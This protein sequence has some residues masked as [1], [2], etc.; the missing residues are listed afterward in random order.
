MTATPGASPSGNQLRTCLRW[1]SSLCTARGA[2]FRAAPGRL[3]VPGS[4]RGNRKAWAQHGTRLPDLRLDLTPTDASTGSASRGLGTLKPTTA[5]GAGHGRVLGRP[6][7]G[8]TPALP[9]TRCANAG[10]LPK[11]A[12]PRFPICGGGDNDLVSLGH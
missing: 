11:R 4:G 7:L 10:G 6:P 5:Q 9:R 2:V 12:V 1:C 3:L 8:V